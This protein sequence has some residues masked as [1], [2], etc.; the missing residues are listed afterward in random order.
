VIET[1]LDFS[2]DIAKVETELICFRDQ[3]LPAF[4]D[5]MICV[6]YRE[7]DREISRWSAERHH[8]YVVKIVFAP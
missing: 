1:E 4:L 3:C 2:A 5:G 8:R 6:L 7:A